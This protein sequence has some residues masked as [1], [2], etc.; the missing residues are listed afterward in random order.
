MWLWLG[1]LLL[2]PFL[3]FVLYAFTS[4]TLK[5]QITHKNAYDDIASL[6]IAAE[7]RGCHL[8]ESLAAVVIAV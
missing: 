4:L 3:F 1:L 7:E 2:L 5:F 8:P 6:S